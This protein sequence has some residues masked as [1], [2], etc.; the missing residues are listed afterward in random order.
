MPRVPIQPTRRSILKT[1]AFLAV[2]GV[3]APFGRVWAQTRL[4]R[5]PDLNRSGF[6][7]DIRV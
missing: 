3:V 7:G 2:G 6:S 1:A 4:R 5:T